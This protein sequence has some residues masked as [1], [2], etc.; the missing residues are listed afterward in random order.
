MTITNTPRV[1][2]KQRSD[3]LLPDPDC[4]QLET[5]DGADGPGFRLIRAINSADAGETD[6]GRTWSLKTSR[7]LH[8]EH[9]GHA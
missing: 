2:A 7:S 5:I 4:P 8:R 3:D 9:L 1:P 6:L